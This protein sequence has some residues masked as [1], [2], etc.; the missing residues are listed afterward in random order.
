MDG[1]A[2]EEKLSFKML[3]LSSAA[4]LDWGSYIVSIVKTVS[5]KIRA[6]IYSMKFFTPEVALYLYESTIQ[7]CMEYY[8]H[9]WAG[10]SSC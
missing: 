10:A 8:F 3:V 2:L 6:L 5:Q 7:P 1:S 4:K 9:D